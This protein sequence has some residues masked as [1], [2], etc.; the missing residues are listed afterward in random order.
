M[1]KG[2]GVTHVLKVNS[3]TNMAKKLKLIASVSSL[4]SLNPLTHGCV[5]EPVLGLPKKSDPQIPAQ[6]L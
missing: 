6:V 1:G 2:L 3:F 5:Y 4:F